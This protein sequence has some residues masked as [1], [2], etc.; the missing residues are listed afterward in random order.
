VGKPDEALGEVVVAFVVARGGV[1]ELEDLRSF[2]GERLAAFKLPS[3]LH[4]VEQI[5]RTGSGK[6]KR[7]QLRDLLDTPEESGVGA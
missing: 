7:H 4:L 6:V 3:E 5:P 2:L 1:L